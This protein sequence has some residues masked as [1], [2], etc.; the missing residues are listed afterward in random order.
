MSSTIEKNGVATLWLLQ[1][2]FRSSMANAFPPSGDTALV[3]H[4]LV[5]AFPLWFGFVGVEEPV[6]FQRSLCS[7]YRGS[8]YKKSRVSCFADASAK[9][10]E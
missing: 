9:R 8:R 2:S 5:S 10:I 3:D 1:G 7:H 6:G 4:P